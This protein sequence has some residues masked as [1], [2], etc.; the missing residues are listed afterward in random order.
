[1]RIVHRYTNSLHFTNGC[2]LRY[3]S[4]QFAADDTKETQRHTYGGKMAN[5]MHDLF[6]AIVFPGVFNP[7][8]Y[9]VESFGFIAKS[10]TK[11]ELTYTQSSEEQRE[12]ISNGTYDIAHS[13]IDN[14]IAMA[15]V[16]SGD[17]RPTRISAA[18]SLASTRSI[19]LLH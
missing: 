18:Q 5:T 2:V 16:A 1:M 10:P 15:D 14:A 4:G 9:A 19:Q 11:L 8:I 3:C 12:G 13:A 6:R 7:P 17:S